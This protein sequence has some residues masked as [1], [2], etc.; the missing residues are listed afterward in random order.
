MQLFSKLY[1]IWF[2]VS[3]SAFLVR[4][5]IKLLKKTKYDS[6]FYFKL[7]KVSKLLGIFH[8]FTELSSWLLLTQEPQT[9]QQLNQPKSSIGLL[10]VIF[11][12]F[13][14]LQIIN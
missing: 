12:F 1:L 11:F 7:G 4:L 8:F 9:V 5:P 13:Y 10:F 6:Y 14:G 3:M 2:Q